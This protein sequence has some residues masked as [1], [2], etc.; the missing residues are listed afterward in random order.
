MASSDGR[1]QV[2]AVMAWSKRAPRAARAERRGIAGSESARRVS[3]TTNRTF[4]PGGAAGR[5]RTTGSAK[6]PCSDGEPLTAKAIST[7]RPAKRE[8]S[9]DSARQLPPGAARRR[10]RTGAPS[11]VTRNVAEGGSLATAAAG[12][13]RRPSSVSRVAP[14]GIATR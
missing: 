3:I 6:K 4:G 10:S 1:V 11:T 5:A 9:I 13:A 8:R 14:G 12:G 7:V 2:A